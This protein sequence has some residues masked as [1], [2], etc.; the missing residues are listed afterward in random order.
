MKIVTTD[1]MMHIDHAAQEKFH[2][3]GI[4]LMEQAGIAVYDILN[5]YIAGSVFSEKNKCRITFIAG[6]GN[7]GGDALAAARIAFTRGYKKISVLLVR[8]RTNEIVHQQR[9][10]CESIGIPVVIWGDVNSQNI[11][12]ESD[13]LI[14]GISGTGLSG[15][16]RGPAREVIEGMGA[17]IHEKKDKIF[18]LSVDLPSGMYSEGGKDSLVVD[19]DCTIT[20]GL[21]KILMYYPHNRMK[22]GK[23]VCRN[24]GFPPELLEQSEGVGSLI[25]L[26]SIKLPVTSKNAYKNTKGHA[27]VF[28]GS[29]GMI[30]AAVLSSTAALR[31]GTGIVSLFADPDVYPAVVKRT[32]SLLVNPTAFDE[33]ILHRRLKE[34]FNALLA[35][36]GWSLSE[37][38]LPQLIEILKSGLPTVLDADGIT[39]YVQLTKTPGFV[40]RNSNCV[41]TPHPGEFLRMSGISSKKNPEQVVA[42]VKDFALKNCCTVVY[43]SHVIYIASAKGDFSVIDGMN[44][45]L[46]TAGSGDVLAGIITGLLAR[47]CDGYSAACLGA[48]MHQIAGKLAYDKIGIF[49]S[50]DLL[51]FISYLSK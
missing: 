25:S 36:P 34:K 27:G 38:H 15:D 42:A 8:E 48:A 7:N 40:H 22:C 17:I 13:F 19:A 50:E 9:K 32:T 18:I 30:G 24:P 26:E 5:E 16:I 28:A 29:S 4:L 51:S 47:G 23:I 31:T 39:L 45:A 3:P 1:I 2:I 6:P 21:P 46:G 35:G 10:M 37:K 43:K 41:F 11:L 49:T 14:D 33:V 44:P 20:M 12:Q